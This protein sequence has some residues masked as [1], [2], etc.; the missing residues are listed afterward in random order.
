ME[1]KCP[2]NWRKGQTLF[3]FIHWVKE[4]YKTD[5]FYMYDHEVDEL[6]DKFIKG[7]TL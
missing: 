4:N 6:Y 2:K 7:H 1:I 3:N 5:I